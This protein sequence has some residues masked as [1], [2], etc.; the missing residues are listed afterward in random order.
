MIGTIKKFERTII[1]SLVIMMCFVLLLSTIE[2]GW[3]MIKD[4]LTPSVFLLEIDELFEIF[5]L[6]MLVLIG[7][8]L[9]ETIIKTYTHQNV[10]HAKIVMA[11]A[12]IAI[13]RKVIILDLEKYSG[14]SLTGI[15]AIILALS[16]GYFLIQLKPGTKMPIE[17][18]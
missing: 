12:L 3:I 15:A 17:K 14:L 4:I 10:N 11:V 6:F 1:F 5:G 7:I 18:E 9:L 8:E 16:L 2:L 13:A